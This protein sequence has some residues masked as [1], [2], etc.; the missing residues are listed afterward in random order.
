MGEGGQGC[1]QGVIMNKQVPAEGN[2]LRPQRG[3]RENV[4]FASE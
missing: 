3:L 1:I 2:Q 4:E